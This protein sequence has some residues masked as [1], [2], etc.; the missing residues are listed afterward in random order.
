MSTAA[1]HKSSVRKKKAVKWNMDAT[2][3]VL[4]ISDFVE[5]SVSTKKLAMVADNEFY[6][7]QHQQVH[8]HTSEECQIWH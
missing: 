2:D 7:G 4:D 6:F 3:Y 1:Q 5:I 8:W